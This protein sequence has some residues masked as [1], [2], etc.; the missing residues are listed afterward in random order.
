MGGGGKGV[1]R[2]RLI[3]PKHAALGVWEARTA[4]ASAV[5][6]SLSSSFGSPGQLFAVW[7]ATA[8]CPSI[9]VLLPTA[10]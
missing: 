5:S 10:A 7:A 1:K 9:A 8:V 4:A 2:I 3:W 6:P